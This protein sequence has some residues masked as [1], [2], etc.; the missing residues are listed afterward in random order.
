MFSILILTKNEEQDLPGC[1][2]SL[3]WSDDIH[4]FDS[5]SV[6]GTLDI[7]R[8]AGAHIVQRPLD[9]KSVV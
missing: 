7:A 9:R 6:D 3:Q 4:V 2:E 8:A 5:Y 1:L